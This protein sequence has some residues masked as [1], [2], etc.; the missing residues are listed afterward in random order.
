MA[1]RCPAWPKL[2]AGLLLRQDLDEEGT[3]PPIGNPRSRHVSPSIS[4]TPLRQRRGWPFSGHFAHWAH[5]VPISCSWIMCRYNVNFRG[6]EVDPRS[7]TLWSPLISHVLL[8]YASV[9][10]LLR[11]LDV[12]LRSPFPGCCAPH[13]RA[14][15]SRTP[16]SS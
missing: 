11:S 15:S 13:P 4:P 8:C 3:E 10:G 14:L 1:A 9:L 16:P 5:S 2:Q 6:I 12:T 7:H